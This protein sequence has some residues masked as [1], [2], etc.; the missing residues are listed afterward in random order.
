MH[1]L[2]PVLMGFTNDNE[3]KVCISSL[4]TNKFKAFTIS[5]FKQCSHSAHTPTSVPEKK[6]MYSTFIFTVRNS[7]CGKVMF[8]RCVCLSTGRAGICL[9]SGGVHNPWAD[10]HRQTLLPLRQTLRPEETSPQA[11]T[12]LCRHH[13]R[14]DTP[15]AADGTHP[16]GMHSCSFCCHFIIFD[17]F[18]TQ[19]LLK[20]FLPNIKSSSATCRRTAAASL[21]LICQECRKPPTFFAWLLN[22]LLGE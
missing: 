4:S 19:L 18:L 11:D 20:A 9:G 7:S 21:T 14:A 3:V 8:Y 13:P 1:K 17:C 12:P 16:A 6:F 15:T 22:V 10:T 2:C 5:G